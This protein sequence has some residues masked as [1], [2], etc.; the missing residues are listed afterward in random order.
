M[1]SSLEI[2]ESL[3]RKRNA[4]YKFKEI[5]ELAKLTVKATQDA[6][7]ELRQ[8]HPN[9][10]FAKFDKT[11]Y[12]GET[13]THYYNQTDLSREMPTSGSFGLISDTHLGSIA[14]RLDIV[15]LAYE[16]Y[17]KRGITK[18]FHAG[19][20][21]DGWDEY[22]G[23]INFVKVYGAAPQAV[24]VIKSYPKVEG[25]TT[26]VI[27]GNHDDESNRRKFDRLSMVVNGTDFEGKHYEGRKDIVLLGQYSHTI[28]L[29][30]EVTMQLL[31]PRGNASYAKSYKQQKRSES[32]DK[33]IRPDIQVSGHFHDFNCMW[34]NHTYFLALPGVQDA[35]EYF[36]RLGLPRG[37]GFVIAHYTIDKGKLASFAPELFMFS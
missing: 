27:G 25:I 6:I 35:T 32:M 9:L 2:V 16:T 24:R 11:Y 28:I 22:R 19:D 8:K 7:F 5:S 13:P 23:H 3:L 20:M 21:T 18:V 31:H 30:Q 10:I 12:F 14:E 4:R 29:P 26:Y 33:N 17:A 15:N 34:A 36:V 1:K 37:V